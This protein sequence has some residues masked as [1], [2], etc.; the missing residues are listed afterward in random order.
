LYKRTREGTFPPPL[1]MGDDRRAS[2]WVEHELHA[3]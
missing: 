1:K 3:V 2:A